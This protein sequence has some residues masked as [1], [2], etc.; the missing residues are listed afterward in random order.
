M[1]PSQAQMI[2]QTIA[3]T[4]ESSYK[5]ALKTAG[6]EAIVLKS[7]AAERP[8]GTID[9]TPEPEWTTK[10]D[11]V[12]KKRLLIGP[13]TSVP[14]RSPALVS[15]LFAK[16]K[17]GEL[18]RIQQIPDLKKD[19]TLNVCGCPS[20][21]PATGCGVAP[22]PMQFYFELPD[23]LTFIKSIDIRYAAE[24][25]IRNFVGKGNGPCAPPARIPQSVQTRQPQK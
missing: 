16:N 25:S 6:L 11:P 21:L 13:L 3:G 24:T 18:F 19:R 2:E 22:Y 5:A 14:C 1:P 20:D 10:I 8:S 9:A 23:G 4:N 7:R 17:Q 15:F 12:S